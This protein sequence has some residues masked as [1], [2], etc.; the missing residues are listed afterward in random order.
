MVAT[1][2]P[3][4]CLKGTRE[5]SCPHSVLHTQTVYITIVSEVLSERL[6]KLTSFFCFCIVKTIH[7][8]RGNDIELI[9]DCNCVTSTNSSVTDNFF[10][11]Q[12]GLSQGLAL[13]QGLDTELDL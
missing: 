3:E 5:C 10:L 2:R 11:K 7:T 6:S 4:Q 8:R 12:K 13:R 1:K 9:D